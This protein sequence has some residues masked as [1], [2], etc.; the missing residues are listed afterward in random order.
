MARNGWKFEETTKRIALDNNM[1]IS[2][3]KKI[4]DAFVDDFSNAFVKGEKVT[5]P[6]FGTI[7]QDRSGYHF[8][9]TN[10]LMKGIKGYDN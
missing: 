1:K 4:F 3:C 8:A 7:Y 9:P 10:S 6:R 5:I 2:D